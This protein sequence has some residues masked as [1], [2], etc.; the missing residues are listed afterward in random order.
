MLSKLITKYYRMY[1]ITN[2]KLAAAIVTFGLLLVTK[3]AVSFGQTTSY[4]IGNSLTYD[5][6][7]NFM[8]ETSGLE[9]IAAQGGHSL[10]AGYHVDS[11]RPLSVI[12]NDPNGVNAMDPAIWPV[13]LQSPYDYVTLQPHQTVGSTLGSDRTAITNFVNYAAGDPVFYVLETWPKDDDPNEPG[14]PFDTWTD[15]VVDDPNTRTVKKRQYF[16]HLMT[17]TRADNPDTTIWMVPTGE[18]L[19]ELNARIEEGTLPDVIQI[20]DL[21]RDDQHLDKAAGRYTAAL[22][23]YSTMFQVDPRGLE[24]PSGM[25]L[26]QTALTNALA[27]AIQDTVWDVISNSEWSGYSDFN[28]DGLINGAD[29]ATWENSNRPGVDFLAWQRQVSFDQPISADFN[30]D[31]VVDGEDFLVLQRGY[32]LTGA[33]A[34]YANGDANGD[35]TIDG[36][37]LAIWE[38]TYDSSSALQ[39][40]GATVPEPTTFILALVGLTV[41][42]SRL[43]T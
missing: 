19:Y 1:V 13:A 34:S 28:R 2:R 42:A 5:S 16:D 6:Q 41:L 14:W 31:N 37:D 35:D 36:K 22:T 29:L 15:S 3:G 24:V 18:V 4:H 23:L 7:G 21:F 39:L 20:E 17:H 12:W 40:S 38:A 8:G 9:A 26:G 11:S 10:T 33:L 25:F 27:A 43:R 30:G 32:G